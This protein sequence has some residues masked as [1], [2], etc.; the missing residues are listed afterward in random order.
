[1]G[2]QQQQQMVFAKKEPEMP[3]TRQKK[4]GERGDIRNRRRHG[5]VWLRLSF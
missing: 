4:D 3:S 5:L 1:M 2:E